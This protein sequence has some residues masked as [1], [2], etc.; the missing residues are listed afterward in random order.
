MFSSLKKVRRFVENHGLGALILSGISEV[1]GLHTAIDV[2]KR[3]GLDEI[4]KKYGHV[5]QAGP[6]DGMILNAE[7]TWGKS[8]LS[9][10]ILGQYEIDVAN[11]LVRH[12]RAFSRPFVD[13]GAADGYFAVGVARTHLA[14]CVI[15]M[16]RESASQKALARAA[17]INGVLDEVRILG[18]ATQESLLRIIAD[19]PSSVILIDIEGGEFELLS[20]AVMEALA[21]CTIILEVH[22]NLVPNGEVLL[23]DLERV[24]SKYFSV[25][26][27]RRGPYSPNIFEALDGLSD[28]LR[29]LAVSES[30]PENPLWLSLEPR[31][32]SVETSQ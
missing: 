24:A 28:D 17:E 27:F 19:V 5:V 16:E 12:L 31:L 8:D 32:H 4:V 14:S 30:R 22:P 2:A 1:L 3:R 13:I 29:L 23:G 15:A 25:D 7:R 26:R 20:E 10:M 6:F 9:S 21:G 18:E 11:H